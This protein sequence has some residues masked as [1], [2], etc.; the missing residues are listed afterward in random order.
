M[1]NNEIQKRPVTPILRA[2]KIGDIEIFPVSQLNSIRV[3]T[4]DL[5]IMEDKKYT[6]KREGKTIIVKRVPLNK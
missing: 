3:K 6:R 1:N 5:K 2:M 4:S